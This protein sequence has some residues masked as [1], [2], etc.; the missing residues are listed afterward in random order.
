MID[1]SI[2]HLARLTSGFPGVSPALGAAHYEACLICLHDQQHLSGVASVVKGMTETT[3]Q[4]QW[5]ETITEQ[6]QRAWD[7]QENATEWQPVV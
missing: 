4:L 2:L 7:N 3:F 6:M 5:E 1:L